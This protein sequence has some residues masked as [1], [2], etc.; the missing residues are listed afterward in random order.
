M[1]QRKQK[2]RF[3]ARPLTHPTALRLFLSESSR[4][5]A[6]LPLRQQAYFAGALHGAHF[7]RHQHADDEGLQVLHWYQRS[8]A[9]RGEFEEVNRRLGWWTR[10]READHYQRKAAGW[11]LTEEGRA[12]LDAYLRTAHDIRTAGIEDAAGKPVRAPRSAIASHNMHGSKTRFRGSSMKVAIEVDGDSLHFLHHA[13]Q[14]WLL[15]DKPPTGFQW[16]HDAWDAIRDGRG[17]NSGMHAA[18][19]R[20]EGDGG[21]IYQASQM[22]DFAK[23]SRA[24]GFVLAQTYIEAP[25]GRLYAEDRIN[26]Q[27]CN[28]EVKRAALRGQWEYDFENCHWSLLNQMAS[29]I[30][31]ELHNIRNYLADKKGWREQIALAT[32]ISVDDAKKCLIAMIYGATIERDDPQLAIPSIIGTEATVRLRQCERM[33]AL[34]DDVKAAR[35]RILRDYAARSGKRRLVNDAGRDFDPTGVPKGKMPAAQLA[36]L[37]QGAESEALRAC[38]DVAGSSLT[39]LQH[40]G[41]TSADKLDVSRFAAAIKQRIGFTLELSEVQL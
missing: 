37:L 31:L 41:F 26:L 23:R 18:M 17:P 30:G 11:R 7:R 1:A 28:R 27:N 13:A 34:H 6:A 12:M 36:H 9:F 35:S 4:E 33:V 2:Q 15:R 32:G 38:M 25:S 14:A 19:R 20:I 5:F 10:E 22:L 16:A 29:R 39:L 24:P 21:V 3:K 8:L 40:D